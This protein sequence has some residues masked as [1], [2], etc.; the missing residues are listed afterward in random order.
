MNK[1]GPIIVIE[2]DKD[3]QQLLADVFKELAYQ[4]EIKFFELGADALEYLNQ[5]DE[6]P[7]IILSD[8]N[9]PQLTGFEL[10]D[11]I[12]ENEKLRMKCIPYLFFTTAASQSAII[13]AY[14]KSAQGFFIKPFSY[15]DIKRM[16][17]KIVEYWQECSS[18]NYI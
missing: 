2:D 11:R 15:I 14:S 12:I 16:I 4:N 1:L 6:V 17:K 7:F 10:R 8:I 5:T 3:D 13:N 18:P 9:L